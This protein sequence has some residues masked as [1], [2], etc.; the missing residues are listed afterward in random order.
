[1]FDFVREKRRVVQIV[2]VLIILPFAF[3]GLESYQSS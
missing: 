2:L 1:M 3:F